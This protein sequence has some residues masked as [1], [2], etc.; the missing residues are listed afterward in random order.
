MMTHGEPPANERKISQLSCAL[1][2]ILAEVLRRDFYG[3]AALEVS[4][5]DGTI[6]HIL[7]RVERVQR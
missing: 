2:E 6:Q 5:Q 3:K 7:R 4:V 1:A